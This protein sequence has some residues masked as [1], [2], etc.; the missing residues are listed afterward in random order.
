MNL[1]LIQEKQTDMNM[2]SIK[3]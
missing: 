1:I 3:T 2:N